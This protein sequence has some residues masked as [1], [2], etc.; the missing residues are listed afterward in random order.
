MKLM[1][2]L[3]ARQAMVLAF[4]RLFIFAGLCFLVVLPLTFFL[5]RPGMVPVAPRPADVHVEI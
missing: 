2:G 3:V 4:E 5:R 1:S